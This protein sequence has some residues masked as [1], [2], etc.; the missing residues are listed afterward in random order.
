MTK[1][2]STSNYNYGNLMRRKKEVN[3]YY[4]GSEYST[5]NNST[6]VD[7]SE[8]FLHILES[9][10]LLVNSK[11]KR[12]DNI[13]DTESSKEN[14]GEKK[15]NES[16]ISKDRTSNILDKEN[17]KNENSTIKLNNGAN[18]DNY[19][20]LKEKIDNTLKRINKV[21][22]KENL[23]ILKD[24]NI[25]INNLMKNIKANNSKDEIKGNNDKNGEKIINRKNDIKNKNTENKKKSNDDNKD[26]K[27]KPHEIDID[28]TNVDNKLDNIL[29]NS[30]INTKEKNIPSLSHTYSTNTI[31]NI[32]VEI[33]IEPRAVL[34]L[35]EILKFIIQRKIFVMI[36]E[37]YIKHSIFQQYNIALSYFVKICK[38]YPLEK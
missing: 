18:I 8:Y 10:Q 26:I 29:T 21:F 28:I 1:S 7:Q 15:N 4:I 27:I 36:Y 34:N 20:E 24:E 9:Q 13:F 6:L 2:K 12:I 32:K 33:E 31:P 19:D 14:K 30:K 5:K 23:Q 17:K 25:P 16:N 37:S 38:Q 11:L 35:V 3:E 22:P